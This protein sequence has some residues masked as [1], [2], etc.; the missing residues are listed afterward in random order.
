MGVCGCEYFCW[1]SAILVQES[2]RTL[3]VSTI[4]YESDKLPMDWE[5]KKYATL[6]V[7]LKPGVEPLKEIKEMPQNNFGGVKVTGYAFEAD[8]EY[9]KELRQRSWT[10]GSA[11]RG[12][13]SGVGNFNKQNGAKQLTASRDTERIENHEPSEAN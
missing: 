7:R 8:E 4:F 5:E 6:K 3:T 1:L 9:W 12:L 13:F 2:G 10:L 11:L